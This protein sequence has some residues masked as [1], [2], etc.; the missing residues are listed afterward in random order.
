MKTLAAKLFI[1]VKN[2]VMH[3]GRG[4]FK[5]MLPFLLTNQH[6]LERKFQYLLHLDVHCYVTNNVDELDSHTKKLVQYQIQKKIYSQL[7]K[8]LNM[9]VT[10]KKTEY[11]F[12]K[13][14]KPF[15]FNQKHFREKN[16]K[17]DEIDVDYLQWPFRASTPTPSISSST[18]LAS[19]LDYTVN[20]LDT[21]LLNKQ[22]DQSANTS[23]DD[24]NDTE[25][26]QML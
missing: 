16:M 26:D 7:E 23:S 24:D 13:E 5:L 12:Q 8:H 3:T 4:A 9:C 21:T 20:D 15:K 1:L 11:V 2:V 18:V 14:P 22:D 19:H 6:L 25:I 10:P 17:V